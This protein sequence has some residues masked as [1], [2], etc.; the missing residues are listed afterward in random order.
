MKLIEAIEHKIFTLPELLKR[1]NSWR[2][3]NKTIAFT[4]GCFDILHEGHIFSLSQAAKEADY[5]VVAVNSDASIKKLKGEERPINNEKSRSLLLASLI[6]VD[7]VVIFEEDTPLNL[8]QSILPDVLVK[9]GDYT[10]EQIVGSKE[11]ITNGGRV[12]INPIVQGFST[13]S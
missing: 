11:V 2:V 8:I 10:V 3:T 5:L 7:A 9:G 12:V 1:I 6:I 4:N 13:T